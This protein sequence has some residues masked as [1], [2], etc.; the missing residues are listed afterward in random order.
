M[1]G[2]RPATCSFPVDFLQEARDAV[3]RRT[4]AVQVAQR[5]RL[6]LWLAE[7]P[8]A[9]NESAAAVAGMSARQVQ[10]WRRRWREGD[11]SIDDRP[12]RGRKPS[13]S[14]AGSHTRAGTCL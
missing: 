7:W 6:A 10:R 9:S 1:R 3:R 13:F 11:F 8:S 14:P 2:P 5:F 4:V 12:G